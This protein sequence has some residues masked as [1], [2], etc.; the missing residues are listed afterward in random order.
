MGRELK[1][2]PNSLTGAHVTGVDVTGD[3][4]VRIRNAN[5]RTVPSLIHVL[6]DVL[7][8]L[9]GRANLNVDVRLILLK[10]VRTIWNDPAVIADDRLTRD[11]WF[12]GRKRLAV[13]SPAVLGIAV[14]IN[15]SPP[16]KLLREPLII[17]E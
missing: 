15:E 10:E 6:V 14:L 7:D 3:L 17:L 12:T 11:P 4:V 13:V 5:R 9:Y 2:P 16:R 8:R 1:E